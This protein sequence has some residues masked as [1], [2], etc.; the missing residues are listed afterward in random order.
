MGYRD[1][2]ARLYFTQGRYARAIEEWKEMLSQ[3]P[4]LAGALKGIARSY[5]KLEAWPMA[6]WHYERALTIE[7][8]DQSLIETIAAVR[9]RLET[10]DTS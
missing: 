9:G 2:L 6:L 7:P 5:E 3:N 1:Q 10:N 4:N 8:D